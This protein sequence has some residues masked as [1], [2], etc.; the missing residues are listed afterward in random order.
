METM[1]KTPT[2][3][4]SLF[5]TYF[6]IVQPTFPFFCFIATVQTNEI[7]SGLLQILTDAFAAH[8]ST[9][10]YGI[11]WAIFQLYPSSS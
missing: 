1:K 4:T 7:M 3:Y 9:F 2:M 5:P 11:A 6:N 8:Y 10:A